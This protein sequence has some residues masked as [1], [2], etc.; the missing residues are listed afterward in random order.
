[1]FSGI[2]DAKGSIVSADEVAGGRKLIIRARDY[3]TDVDQGGSIAI[4][5]VCLTLTRSDREQAEFDV[6]AE[7]LRRTTLGSL[8]PG[9]E[10]NLQKSLA[11]GDRIDG[12]F[13]QGHV[14]ATAA[15]AKV[16]QS[17]RESIW[18]FALDREA[19]TY[20]TPKGSIAVDGISLTVVDV[21]DDLFGVALIPTTLGRTTIGAKKVGDRVNIET[22]VLARTVVGYL[23]NLI[24]RS[25]GTAR[26]ITADLLS[27][28][29]FD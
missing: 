9:G 10:V 27:Q 28:M 5:G 17:A 11:A 29:G 21:R 14:D 25:S 22:D 20:V 13:V 2:I 16:E 8:R 15:V 18:W 12:H 23:R 1:M 24:S 4:D 7:T 6:I 26:G 19:L 3:W